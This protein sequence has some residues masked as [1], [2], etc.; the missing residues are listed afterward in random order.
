MTGRTNDLAN[1]KAVIN[2]TAWVSLNEISRG[3]LSYRLCL[4]C[5]KK[6][7]M[8]KNLSTPWCTGYVLWSV[9]WGLYDAFCFGL[10]LQS[11]ISMHNDFSIF[12]LELQGLGKSYSSHHSYNMSAWNFFPSQTVH[13]HRHFQIVEFQQHSLF[14]L[15]KG[16]YMCYSWTLPWE[17]MQSGSGLKTQRASDLRVRGPW[18]LSYR[19]RMELVC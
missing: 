6:R 2:F 9:W 13:I 5:A 7:G 14:Y 1:E 18:I 10:I 8:S 15:F 3:N 17:C 11:G 4:Y 16:V 19:N 12:F